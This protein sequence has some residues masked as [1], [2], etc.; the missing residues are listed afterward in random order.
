LVLAEQY[1]NDEN[2]RI[3]FRMFLNLSFFKMYRKDEAYQYIIDKINELNLI[4]TFSD[5]IIYFLKMYFG[6]E[7]KDNIRIRIFVISRKNYS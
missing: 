6:R 4:A 3:V 5:F 1:I 2:I 7:N